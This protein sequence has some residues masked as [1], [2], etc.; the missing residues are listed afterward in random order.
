MAKKKNK[1]VTDY[2]H[3][4]TRKNNPPAGLVD[5]EPK[6]NEPKI[7][8]YAYNPHLSPQLV[9]A[10]KPGLISIEVEDQSGVKA[11]T[12][13]L[14]VHERISSQAI[15]NSV[16]REEPQINLFAKPELSFNE[17]IKFYQHDVNWSNRLILGDS[18]LVAN[19]LIER[20]MMAGK[21]QMIYMDP[22]YGVS[23]K[24]NFQVRID[25]RVV[26][27][28]DDDLTR[29]PEMIKAYRDTWKLGIHSY[30]TYMRDRLRVARE[31]LNDS[32]SIFVQI[33]DENIHFVRNLMD[34]VFG[35]EN[36]VSQ[37]SMKRPSVMFT[38]KYL[39]SD[40]FY[41]LFYAKNLDVLKFKKLYIK[42]N[43]Q[44][45]ANV[46]GS[47]LW[48]H[49]RTRNIDMKATPDQRKDISAYL[50]RNPENDVFATLGLNAQGI[51]K[52]KGFTFNGEEYFPP[53]GTQWKSSY[54]GLNTLANANRIIVE[55]EKIR[56]KYYFDDYPLIESG[57]Y[58]ESIG[59]P[60]EKL[61]VV[62]T[63]DEI[64]KRC[65]MMTTD[66]GDLIFDPTCGSGTTANVAE[67]WG[68]R[69]ITC[70]TSRVAISIA[71]QRL[72]TA[73]YPYYMIDN[74][75]GKH[76]PGYGFKYKG[77]PHITLGAIAQNTRINLVVEEYNQKIE[78]AL[79]NLNK[80]SQLNYKE[81]EVP[82]EK[83]DNWD[84]KTLT[85]WK[86]IRQLNRDKQKNIDAII[87]EDT[88]QETLYDMPD[89][90]NK[91][92]RVSGPFT[93]EAIPAPSL[94][95]SPIEGMNE[96]LDSFESDSSVALTDE[97]HIPYLITLMQK[98]GV[99]FPD[100]KKIAFDSL[101]ARSGGVI[102]AEGLSKGQNVGISFGPLHGPVSIMQVTD[103]LRE[104]NLAGFDEIIFCGFAFDPEA[105]SIINEN[106]HPRVQAHMSH[107][108][109]DILLTDDKGESLL[110]TTTAS[111]LFTVFGEPDIELNKSKGEYTI[112]LN[113][114]DVYDP[115][116]GSVQ[117]EKAER[118][119]AWFV[120]TDYDGRTF[121]ISQAF[122]PDKSAWKKI[123][124]ALK[125]TLDEDSFALLTG[126]VSLPFKSGKHDIIAV[127]V[128]DPRGNEVMKVIKL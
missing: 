70:D 98:D 19:S 93:V 109:P 61:Y 34:E 82:F 17:A 50:L 62:Q 6:V 54:E 127:K 107:I 47:H 116:S 111:Q 25:N 35:V 112:T 55:G 29:E 85:A 53:T 44:Q 42:Q 88:R 66:P 68:R 18:L 37:I 22:P 114:I 57:N 73:L 105:Q 5:Y 3:K 4:E 125:G 33:S 108:R 10:D 106:P 110:K 76:N 12:V 14:H 78:K 124:R 20:E 30:L 121:C 79:K 74:E 92:A 80:K 8:Q 89:I 91:I 117:S 63:N 36:F 64:I 71:R 24:S 81:W 128:I 7:K 84:E 113:G 32:G 103:G 23:Y 101:N 95:E 86:Q 69:W 9:W 49:D 51:E 97:N 21:V 75:D 72:L 58:W 11:E 46:S 65:I 77:F 120:D 100:N 94:E 87:A 39:K 31:L 99:L 60:G 102:H 43:V 56:Y 126:H 38:K 2:R 59:A 96:E 119:A 41:L 90:N 115:V 45:F 118:V 15:I 40:V 122:F 48:F 104:A 52:Q 16:K 67:K 13:S 26:G 83:E 1:S 27:D 123:E 28:K